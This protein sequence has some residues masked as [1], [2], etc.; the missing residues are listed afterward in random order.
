M[1]TENVK[2]SNVFCGSNY[3]FFLSV[4]QSTLDLGRLLKNEENRILRCF[5][6]EQ[7]QQFRRKDEP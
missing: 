5:F 2:T 4:G 3:P 7:W 1:D 6:E